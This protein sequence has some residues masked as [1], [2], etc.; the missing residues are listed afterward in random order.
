MRDSD[1]F[2]S[3]LAAENKMIVRNE[4]NPI[5]NKMHVKLTLHNGANNLTNWPINKLYKCE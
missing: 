4:P 3:Q 2:E 1:L 5:F